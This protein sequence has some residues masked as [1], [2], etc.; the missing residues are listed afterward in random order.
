MNT[1][2]A[3]ALTST[4]TPV[5]LG[6]KEQLQIAQLLSDAINLY[7]ET[8]S[9][10]LSVS[11]VADLQ[12]RS[13]DLA[14]EVFALDP[15]NIEALNVLARVRLDQNHL[16]LAETIAQAALAIDK[17]SATSWYSY[18]QVQLAMGN[19]NNAEQAFVKCISLD[20]TFFRAHTSYAFTKLNKGE[21]A[22]AFQHYTKLA[23]IKPE[24]DHI[25]SKLFECM[26]Q[27]KADYDNEHL[28]KALVDYLNWKDVNYQDLSNII[29]SLLV[30]RYKLD[31][32]EAQVDLSKLCQDK[33][34]NEGLRKLFF[35]NPKIEELN[36]D[37]RGY[38][39]TLDN[40]LA[41]PDE[42]HLMSS[43]VYQLYNNEYVLSYTESEAAQLEI[44]CQQLSKAD[45][46][47]LQQ[48]QTNLLKALL[49][50]P[51]KSTLSR[52]QIIELLSRRDKCWQPEIFQLITWLDKQEDGES[53]AGILVHEDITNQTSK[54]VKAQYEINP[55]PR[56]LSLDFL[57]PTTYGVALE[58]ALPLHKADKHFFSDSLDIL[59][60]G[61]GTGR[62]AIQVARYFRGVN[63]TA[64]DVSMHSL[65]YANTMAKKYKL[66]NI[67]FIQADILNLGNFDKRFDIIECSGVLHHMADPLE[68]AQILKNLLK[69]HGLLKVGLYSERARSE[70][71]GCRNLISELYPETNSRVIRDF[72]REVLKNANGFPQIVQSADFYS[73]SGCRDLLFHVQ[74]HRFTPTSLKQL[75][76]NL[77]MEFLGFVQVQSDYLKAYDERFP[78]DQARTDL[79][80][81]EQLED[82]IPQIFSA[83]YQFY[84][85]NQ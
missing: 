17:N 24:D 83:M 62:H 39:L 85:K 8:R 74:E 76:D 10:K 2:H 82:D 45:L 53:T 40:Q 41:G 29:E 16:V 38:F 71:V 48:Q 13:I 36:R 12:E 33:L 1:Q 69:T 14:E 57:T 37:L 52:M 75:I 3:A 20:A 5:T 77:G 65:S 80:N 50:R 31:S 30:H 15:T 9:E 79:A 27:L 44:I 7:Q 25:R 56:W 42:I 35:C 64:I 34:Y 46:D 51:L 68:G 43:L 28:G 11:E 55:Y 58:K 61:C 6:K 66:D 22:A 81:W 63:V 60:A 18:G 47:S 21:I 73:M 49:Y 4:E 54:A 26:K 84:L 23:K 67:E 59:I 19:L 72:R 32:S 78:L 70:V